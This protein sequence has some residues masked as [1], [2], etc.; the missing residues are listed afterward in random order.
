MAKFLDE[1]PGGNPEEMRELNFRR[2]CW[3]NSSEKFLE[4]ISLFLK[5][6]KI[7]WNSWRKDTEEFLIEFLG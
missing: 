5:K 2:N 1:I 4:E 6:K 3:F 7:R